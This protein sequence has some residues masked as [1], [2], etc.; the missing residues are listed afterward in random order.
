MIDPLL[1][2]AA[3]SHPV[4]QIRCLETHIS[5]VILTGPYAY[6]IKKPVNLGFLDFSTLAKRHQFCDEELRLNRRFAPQ[7]YIDVVAIGGTVEQPMLQA[8]GD[9][10][11]DAVALGQ[12]LEF[13]AVARTGSPG[14]DQHAGPRAA[15]Y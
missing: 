5:W 12:A 10:I 11:E 7:L 1:S 13:G 9:S 15:L 4:H 2:A 8:D 6:K 3:Y 14:T